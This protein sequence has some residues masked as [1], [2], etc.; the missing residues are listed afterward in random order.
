M[1][2]S[3]FVIRQVVSKKYTISRPRELWIYVK[4]LEVSLSTYLVSMSTP[5]CERKFSRPCC[6]KSYDYRFQISSVWT[7]YTLFQYIFTFHHQHKEYLLFKAAVVLG[8]T[9]TRPSDVNFSPGLCVSH[10]TYPPQQTSQ[11]N[12]IKCCW[13]RYENL[14]IFQSTEA[15]CSERS[16]PLSLLTQ[17]CVA[18]NT[19]SLINSS[20]SQTTAAAAVALMT[21]LD[22]TYVIRPR[23]TLILILETK[24]NTT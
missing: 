9:T 16:W 4:K 14:H 15:I 19:L 20:E 13:N 1:Q 17:C 24:Q 7:P 6:R 22:G 23:F 11:T 21:H 12:N 5:V 8:R 18:S 10:T 3:Y 2:I